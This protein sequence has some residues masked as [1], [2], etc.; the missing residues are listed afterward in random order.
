MQ[1][2]SILKYVEKRLEFSIST[3]VKDCYKKGNTEKIEDYDWSFKVIGHIAVA[4]KAI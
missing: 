4:I 3:L 1:R 2:R